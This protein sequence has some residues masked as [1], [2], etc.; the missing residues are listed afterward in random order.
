MSASHFQGPSFILKKLNALQYVVTKDVLGV[1]GVSLCTGVLG[2]WLGWFVSVVVILEV[3]PIHTS[4]R[5]AVRLRMGVRLHVLQYPSMYL[6]VP[7]DAEP[8]SKMQ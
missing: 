4:S 1:S 5:A 3:H 6:F 7:N 8:P 2:C